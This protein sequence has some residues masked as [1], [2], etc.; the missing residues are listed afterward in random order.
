M[1]HK[2]IEFIG[3]YIDN[4]ENGQ[5]IKRNIIVCNYISWLID[6]ILE[7]KNGYIYNHK[8]SVLWLINKYINQVSDD[9]QIKQMLT[10]E[11]EFRTRYNFSGV[12][13]FMYNSYVNIKKG[14][15][16]YSSLN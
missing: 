14:A 6:N 7:H 3:W 1:H 10:T 9:T 13:E 4:F 16:N 2:D 5:N 8:V 11:K 15:R 12:P